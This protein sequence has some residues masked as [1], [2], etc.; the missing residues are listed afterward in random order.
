MKDFSFFVGA[1]LI[2]TGCFAQSTY[3][4]DPYGNLVQRDQY[5]NTQST[6]SRDPY[7]NLVQRDQY[8]NTQS[9]TSRDP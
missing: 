6:T 7:G 8:G 1:I 9:T 5:G 4:R 3:S 2:S